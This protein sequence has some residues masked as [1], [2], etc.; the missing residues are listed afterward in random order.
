MFHSTYF[1]KIAPRYPS[2]TLHDAE[3]DYLWLRHGTDSG[4]EAIAGDPD[5]VS[6][7]VAGRGDARLLGA[8][9]SPQRRAIGRDSKV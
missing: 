7:D 1:F 8:V 6:G 4:G 2:A 9:R 3:R 5:R